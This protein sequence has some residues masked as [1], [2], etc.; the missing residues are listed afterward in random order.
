MLSIIY[1]RTFVFIFVVF[2]K[3]RNL[4]NDFGIDNFKMWIYNFKKKGGL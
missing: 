4:D 1:K 3:K 2:V